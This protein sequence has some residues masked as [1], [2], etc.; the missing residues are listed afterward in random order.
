MQWILVNSHF[1]LEKSSRRKLTCYF[2]LD[3]AFKHIYNWKLKI[4]E[5]KVFFICCLFWVKIIVSNVIQIYYQT[6]VNIWDIQDLCTAWRNTFHDTLNNGLNVLANQQTSIHDDT[7]YRFQKPSS[8]SALV[9]VYPVNKIKSKIYILK[10]WLC[11]ISEYYFLNIILQDCLVYIW[12]T[13]S[14]TV[15]L[16]IEDQRTN[17]NIN[18]GQI[19]KRRCDEWFILQ[20][21]QTLLEQFLNRH[22]YMYILDH[23]LSGLDTCTSIRNDGG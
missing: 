18:Y 5:N 21:K 17:F 9:F 22:T 2:L 11:I 13:G 14:F 16:N 7:K 12:G 8:D 23:L 19:N 1:I 20:W 3:F 10:I 4:L 6:L 15:C